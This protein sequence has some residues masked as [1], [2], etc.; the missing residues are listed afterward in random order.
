MAHQRKPR[1]TPSSHLGRGGANA[2]YSPG[3]LARVLGISRNGVYAAL[4]SGKIPHIR[5]GRRFVI[6]KAA[7]D[8]WFH[9]IG[10]QTSMEQRQA[11][12]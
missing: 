3:D 4:R 6:P 5:I 2:T 9:S 1:G 11:L 10:Q 7:V 8:S 12:L